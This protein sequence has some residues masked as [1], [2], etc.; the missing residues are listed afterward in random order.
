MPRPSRGGALATTRSTPGHLRHHDGHERGGEHRVA[1]ARHVRAD[2]ADRHVAVAEPD[3]AQRLDLEVRERL[4]LALR[5]VAH[6]RLR[7]GDV[8]AE[9]LRK[10]GRGRRDLVGADQER[11][12]RPPVE[13]KRPVAH[14]LLAPPL[15]VR[16]Q[17]GDGLREPPRRRRRAAWPQ[18]ASGGAPPMPPAPLARRLPAAPRRSSRARSTGRP[19]RPSARRRTRC[20]GPPACPPSGATTASAA[21]ASPVSPK[22][23]AARPRVSGSYSRSSTAYPRATVRPSSRRSDSGPVVVRSVNDSSGS[24]STASRQL[25]RHASSALPAAVQWHGTSSR[26]WGRQPEPTSP[27][28]WTRQS[29]DR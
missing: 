13:A 26:R 7:E 28:S 20:T 29:A 11:V 8:A 4:E 14:G 2:R 24:A 17:L 21:T 19:P 9:V 12:G 3:A 15:D 18:L 1:A 27:A 25:S 10:L 5:E 16:E 23:G 22:T 6:A